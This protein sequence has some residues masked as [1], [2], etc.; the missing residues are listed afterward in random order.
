MAAAAARRAAACGFALRRDHPVLDGNKRLALAVVDVFL[1]MNGRELTA[2]EEDAVLTFRDLAAGALDE[3]G[4][5]GWIR[6][7]SPPPGR[8]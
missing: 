7:N 5:A 2:P 4:L 3:A 8:E 6:A 1:R